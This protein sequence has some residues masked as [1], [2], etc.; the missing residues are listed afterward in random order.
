MRISIS[1]RGVRTLAAQVR[2]RPHRFARHELDDFPLPGSLLSNGRLRQRTRIALRTRITWPA[3]SLSKYC[4]TLVAVAAILV[5]PAPACSF[6]ISFNTSFEPDAV[7]LPASEVRRLAEW[8][9]DGPGKYENKE[10]FHIFLYEAPS[11]GISHARA[12][13]RV[14]HLEHLLTALDVPVSKISMEIGHYK[15][16]R[17]ALPPSFAQI[18]FL[19][20]CPHPCC[21]GPQPTRMP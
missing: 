5:Q 17:S 16:G 20:G 15:P 9:I 19:P 21:P 2:N 12:R 18:D 13:K 14:S 8:M 3:M 6:N 1:C 11:A 10:T 4:R 7:R